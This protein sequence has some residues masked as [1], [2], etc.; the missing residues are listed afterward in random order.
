[1]I[2]RLLRLLDLT[3]EDLA[4]FRELLW[5]PVLV[6]LAALVILLIYYEIIGY[7]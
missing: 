7:H 4:E 6:V 5:W 2:P 3:P 1:M